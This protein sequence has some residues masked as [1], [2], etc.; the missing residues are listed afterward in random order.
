MET[1]DLIATHDRLIKPNKT[2]QNLKG[3]S[4]ISIHGTQPPCV[5]CRTNDSLPQGHSKTRLFVSSY[6]S[7]V[8]LVTIVLAA[9]VLAITT[10]GKPQILNALI[11][12]PPI[13]YHT[14]LV[15]L[16]GVLSILL[17]HIEIQRT[18]ARR[19]LQK[20]EENNQA[21]AKQ[22]KESMHAEQQRAKEEIGRLSE[23]LERRVKE[24]AQA[25]NELKTLATKFEE[26]C[27]QALEASRLKSEFLANMSHE[28]R[29]PLNGVLGMSDLLLDTDL[30]IEQEQFLL[31]LKESAQSL[32]GVINDVLD[33]SKIEAGKLDLEIL[34][35]EVVSL[36]EDTAEIVAEQAHQKKLSLMT[37]IAPN[38][39]RSLQGD[40]QR[41]RQ[42]LINLLS[43]A[44]KF[45]EQGEVKLTC[46]IDETFNQG[47]VIRFAVTDTGIGLPASSYNK[48]FQPFSQVDGSIT[49]KFG[50]TGLGLS[51]CKQLVDLMDGLI[52]VESKEGE[53]S[54]FWF[55]VPL[56]TSDNTD[57][58]KPTQ[59]QLRDTKLL[60]VAGQLSTTEIIS[61]YAEAWGIGLDT[62]TTGEDALVKLQGQAT[63]GNPYHVVIVELSSAC[64][65]AF[66]IAEE[67]RR[68]LKQTNVRLILIAT[69]DE[70]RQKERALRSG[71]SAYLTKPFKQSRLLG[72]INNLLNKA[73][74]NGLKA[75][76]PTSHISHKAPLLPA[77]KSKLVLVAED[78]SVNRLVAVRQLER[79]GFIAHVVTTGQ[80]AVEASKRLPYALILMDCQMPEMDGFEAT[81]LI[82]QAE[83]LCE[84]HVPIIAITAHALEGD[85]EKCIAAG[86]D[87]YISKPVDPQKLQAVLMRWVPTESEQAG[88]GAY[89]ARAI[90]PDLAPELMLHKETP[91]QVADSQLSCSSLEP[92]LLELYI[93]SSQKILSKM[94]EALSTNDSQ[95]LMSLAHEL[96]A[97]SAAV[98]AS[99][100][101]KLSLSLEQTAGCQNWA[102]TKSEWK[103]LKQSFDDVQV[104]ANNLSH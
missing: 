98:G 10:T 62:V 20:A 21:I 4:S 53:G 64:V 67:I 103:A 58:P 72:C 32:L 104:I 87:D 23:T 47:L 50:G 57:D 1:I 101:A 30:N 16:L 12:N 90:K 42:V 94:A 92:K 2:D 89:N 27:E 102:R 37:Y 13:P 68:R 71:Y 18:N 85:R 61:S 34:D 75:A 59:Q 82:R 96:K 6:A 78:N 66:G 28:M 69:S 31:V 63:L 44:I 45:T 33:F 7:L 80:E 51:I 52:G 17:V 39:P 60:L 40:A 19:A 93:S 41:L 25:N 5:T 22:A 84:Q 73:P 3:T 11:N 56:K 88:K 76:P 91:S 43:N 8:S 77:H 70:G 97:S 65:D 24:L 99:E 74:D 79:L 26:A 46:T 9:M 49:R 38:V 55:T 100:I 86:M 54:T 29:T 81:R 83:A 36:I 15:L 35:F 14:A 48:L 95:R